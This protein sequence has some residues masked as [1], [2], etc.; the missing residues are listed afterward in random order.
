MQSLLS[1]LLPFL[2]R[3]RQAADTAL[4]PLRPAEQGTAVGAS[5][6]MQGWPILSV[7]FWEQK[8][9]SSRCS[10]AFLLVSVTITPLP[11]SPLPQ[12]F[13]VPT[14]LASSHLCSYYCGVGCGSN[15]LL[16]VMQSCVVQSL[17]WPRGPGPQGVEERGATSLH[18]GLRGGTQQV[19]IS[20][21]V[22]SLR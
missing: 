18:V 10:L 8:C 2:K 14:Y 13:L 19:K 12:G 7:T 1:L 20:R 9:S 5:G 16:T 3:G 17:L 4:A 15:K 6:H 22:V 11:A 21:T